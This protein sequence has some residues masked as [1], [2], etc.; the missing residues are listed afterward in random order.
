M[1]NAWLD[2][3]TRSAIP[4][5]RGTDRYTAGAQCIIVTWA[6]EDGP[7][8]IWDRFA[9]VAM[10]AELDRILA[11]DA[12]I[13]TAHNAAFDR[14][15][16][17]RSL[18]RHTPLHRWRCTQAKAYAHGLPG[19]LGLLGQV[20]AL[21]ECE[22]KREDDAKL[23]HLFC[24]PRADGS[25]ATPQTHPAEW[26]RFRQ[27]A[28]NDTIALREIDRRLPN[29][30]YRGENLATWQLCQ[31]INERGIYFD[32]A[33][34]Q[35][36][37]ELLDRAKQLHGAQVAEATRG[38]V[39]AAT[40]RQKLLD[41]LSAS[42]LALPNMQAAT[43]REWLEHDD[44]RPEHRFILELRLEAARSSGSKYR[45]GLEVVGAESR[46]RFGTQFNGAGRTGRW[47]GRG[48]Q[49][50]NMARPSV[51][52]L[53]PVTGN[54]K[55]RSV[56][57]QYIEGV[58]IPGIKSG[59][60]LSE[61]LLYGGPNEA[62]SNAL[63]GA[64]TA[65]PGNELVVADWSNIEGRILAWITDERWKLAAYRATD[66]GEAADG[67]KLL[68]SRFFGAPVETVDDNQRQ[69][70]KVVDLACGYLGSTGAF[71]AMAASYDIDLNTLPPLVLP[72]AQPEH[73]KRAQATWRRAFLNGEDYGLEPETFVACNVLVQVY[74]TANSNIT[75]TGRAVGEACMAAV[76]APGTLHEIARCKIWS[77][78][79]WLIIQLPSGRRLLYCKPKTHTER[80]VD[81]ETGR[82][83]WQEYISYLTARGKTWRRERA[84]A[85]LFVENI[86]QAIA[87]D[88]L[89]A[90]LLL[91]DE[92]AWTIPAVANYL[93][94]LPEYEQ[95]AI[96]LH[97]HDEIVL[98]VPPGTY[99][100]ERLQQKMTTDLIATTPWVTGLPL[101]ASGWTG[102]RYHK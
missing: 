94:T 76:R 78:A 79:A 19:S 84:W 18:H 87:N 8:Q 2:T 64:I 86:V 74:R 68:Y 11:G 4:I 23:I 55:K 95:T 50:H 54:F 85:G 28:I 62:C 51:S 13:L 20:L 96:S 48:F 58:I 69:V 24:V 102:V 25:W 7:A 97:V 44:L 38:D 14:R 6:L 56:K 81:P 93:R 72:S 60:A 39:T 101:A 33:F 91:A 27:Y 36:A 45:R 65:A 17:E 43:I 98:D 80:E 16:I 57:H 59:A 77:T 41:W 90:A 5:S 32:Q 66:R 63:R 9:D 88:I 29:H 52:T 42:G 22:R 82:E 83:R 92:D 37:C 99:P 75:S 89:R 31:K 15:I 30:N 53:D 67:Y 21:P 1:P 26:A 61:P 49:P 40:Q 73:L 10:P 70:G 46:I 47:S 3:E 71:A 35:A 100:L 34:A 12:V